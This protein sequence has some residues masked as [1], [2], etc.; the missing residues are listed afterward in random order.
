MA[1]AR[2][3]NVVYFQQSSEPGTR[4]GGPTVWEG[5]EAAR[6]FANIDFESGKTAKRRFAAAGTNSER[7]SQ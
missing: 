1:G 5:A 6:R 3:C 4:A 7:T 2:G